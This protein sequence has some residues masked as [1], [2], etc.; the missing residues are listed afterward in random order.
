[1]TIFC[2]SSRN[3]LVAP[4]VALYNYPKRKILTQH[5]LVKNGGSFIMVRFFFDFQLSFNCLFTVLFEIFSVRF[6]V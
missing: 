2:K 1:M 4:I 3:G 6:L 5:I